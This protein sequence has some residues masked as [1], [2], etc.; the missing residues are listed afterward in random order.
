MYRKIWVLVLGCLLLQAAYPQ[1]ISA[2]TKAE[3]ETRFAE[4]IKAGIAKLGTGKDARIEVKLQDGTKL[5]GYVS[6]T[7]DDHFVVMNAKTGAA[8]PVAYPQVKQVKGNNLSE[9]VKIAIGLAIGIG[10]AVILAVAIGSS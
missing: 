3:K 5:K 6:E 10:L 2:M 9:G 1:S 7:T 8:V 4:K